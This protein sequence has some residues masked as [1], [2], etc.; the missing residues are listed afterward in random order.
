MKKKTPIISYR[1]RKYDPAR[2]QHLL[3]S[4]GL[5]Y[6]KLAKIVSSAL[7]SNV[8]YITVR[9]H[10]RGEQDPHIKYIAAYADVFAVPVDYF[11]GG[12]LEY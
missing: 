2:L 1:R 10:V 7:G 9:R 8:Q 12:I 4:E 6:H 11:F 3:D 5:S